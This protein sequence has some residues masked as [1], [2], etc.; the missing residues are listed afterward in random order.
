MKFKGAGQ[1]TRAFISEL[2]GGELA[3][4]LGLRMPEIV[5]MDLNV[6]F[7]RSEGDEE[8]Q[9][10]LKFSEGLNMGLHYLKG[11]VTYDPAV[12]SIDP[13]EASKIVWLDAFIT[14]VDRTARNT[15]MLIWHDDLWLI[16]HGA[17]LYFHHH[18]TD[19]KKQAETPF[20]RIKDHVLFHRATKIK[21][22][23]N[24][25]LEVITP[26]LIESIVE[27]IPNEWLIPNDQFKTTDALRDMYKTFLSHRLQ[28]HYHFLN[29]IIN[30]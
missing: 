19:I 11:A 21:E 1:G 14:N 4:A 5:F 22:V 30:G 29:T 17:A 8:I 12:Y 13:V 6:G 7:G 9:D 16:D 10:L 20:I 28:N 24:L 3:R 15:N 23:T 27:L 26:G 18:V 25:L 2:I